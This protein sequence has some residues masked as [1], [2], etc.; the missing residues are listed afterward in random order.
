[1]EDAAHGQYC[2]VAYAADILGDRWTMLIVR[3]MIGGATRFNEIE[4]LLPRVSRSL[5]AQRL[6]HLTRIGIIAATPIPGGRGSE[7]RLTEAGQDL[8]SVMEAMGVWAVRWIFGDPRP[9]ELDPTFIMWWM[10]RRVIGDELPPG[11]TVVRFDLLDPGR[12]VYWLVLAPEETSVCQTDPLLPVSV[13][14]TADLTEFHR[15]FSGRTTFGEA[16]RG[17]SIT[18]DGPRTL[19][20][21]LPRWFAWSPF[22]DAVRSQ[23]LARSADPAPNEPYEALTSPNGP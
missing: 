3:E 12:H 19:T 7:Y 6:K 2:P 9:E 14:V 18:L 13:Q 8:R 16:L 5:L 10:H 23:A 17:G 22:H 1:M 4:R 21:Q 11:R 15:V 20:R